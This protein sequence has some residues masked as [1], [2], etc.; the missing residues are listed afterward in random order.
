MY[1]LTLT[2]NERKAIDWVGYRDWNGDSLYFLLMK[3]EAT[4]E[5][6][7]WND[8]VDITFNISENKAWEIHQMYEDNGETIPHFSDE[9]KSKIQ[10]F[11]DEIV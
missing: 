10:N 4:P 6:S 11:L 7:F 9:L 8:K 3:C 5:E 2:Y 1:K